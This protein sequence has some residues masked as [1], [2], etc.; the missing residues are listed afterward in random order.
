MTD[1]EYCR[2]CGRF[3]SLRLGEITQV[4]EGKERCGLIAC[5]WIPK[6]GEHEV[7]ISEG[8]TP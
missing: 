1:I 6:I 7:R 4:L 8:D 2:T 5:L 3:D